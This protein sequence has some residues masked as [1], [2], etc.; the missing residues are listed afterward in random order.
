VTGRA[1]AALVAV[2]GGV[3]LIGGVVVFA[4]A[5]ASDFGWTAYTAS[6]APLE[7]APDGS[8]WSIT[9]SDGAVLWTR[10]H[11]VGAG[12]AVLGLLVL[13]GFGGWL[14]GRRS[15]RQRPPAT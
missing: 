8:D 5:N 11:A 1:L 2:L 13:V 7:P 10:G 9:L 15:G 12:L 6:Y 3:A 4:L 14:L